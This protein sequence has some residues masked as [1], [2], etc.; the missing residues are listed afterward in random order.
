D[1]EGIKKI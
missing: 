1:I